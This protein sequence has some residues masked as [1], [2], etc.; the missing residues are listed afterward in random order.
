MT[1]ICISK[2]NTIQLV[3]IMAYHLAGAKPLSEP[4]L[5]Y[6]WLDPWEQTSVKSWIDKFS[7][8]KMHLKMSS[9]NWLPFCLC[10][11]VKLTAAW[12]ALAQVMTCCLTTPSQY[13]NQCC[14]IINWALT[15]K[16]Q[17]NLFFFCKKKIIQKMLY[18][19]CPACFQAS[20]C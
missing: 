11:N 4:M 12:S 15:I 7:F 19:K 13:L 20:M 2:L 17:W 6:C 16:L 9:G 8:K 5:E 3:Q 1:Y 18:V 14:L 10:L